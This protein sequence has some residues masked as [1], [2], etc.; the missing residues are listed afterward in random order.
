MR[1]NKTRWV[2]CCREYQ[3]DAIKRGIVA[4]RDRAVDW[5]QPSLTTD[6]VLRIFVPV[7]VQ[8]L[9]VEAYRRLEISGVSHLVFTDS[10]TGLKCDLY[11]QPGFAS[12]KKFE[13]PPNECPQRA[14]LDAWVWWRFER[15][16]EWATVKAVWKALQNACH[17]EGTNQLGMVRYLWPAVLTLLEAGDE[18]ETADKLRNA[19]PPDYVPSLPM[20]LREA[21]KVTAGI[22]AGTMLLPKPKASFSYRATAEQPVTIRL[23]NAYKVEPIDLG[24]GVKVRPI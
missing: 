13:R 22:I 12:P 11:C 1:S 3:A 21:M 19:R 5:N 15:G 16:M 4:L 6:D 17:R 23:D 18:K 20:A 10:R 8:E 7:E 9:A 14:E 24:W 2:T